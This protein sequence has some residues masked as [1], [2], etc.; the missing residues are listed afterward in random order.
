MIRGWQLAKGDVEFGNA[1]QLWEAAE[2]HPVLTPGIL[3]L[4]GA[5]SGPSY[6]GKL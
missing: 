5:E 6:Q 1:R 3:T 2:A 4:W